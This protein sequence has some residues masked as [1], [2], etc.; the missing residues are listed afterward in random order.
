MV[1]AVIAAPIAAFVI[2]IYT[3]Y[4]SIIAFVEGFHTG[5]ANILWEP[6]PK[7]PE[8]IWEKHVKRMTDKANLN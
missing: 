6:K 4:I 7:E 5:M 3:F 2:A 8:D 1:L